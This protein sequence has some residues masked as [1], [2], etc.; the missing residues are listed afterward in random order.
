[1][2]LWVRRSAGTVRGWLSYSLGWVWST[3]EN[4][5]RPLQS[6]AGRHLISA[7]VEGPLPAGGIFDVRV[8]YGAGLP[9]T[10][11]PEPE[12]AAPVFTAS[13]RQLHNDDVPNSP[14]TPSDPGQ[15]YLRIDAELERTWSGRIGDFEFEVTPYVKVLNALNRRDA[16]FYHFDRDVG[17]AEPLAGLPLLP[18]VGLTW[19]F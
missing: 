10:A 14:G 4:R 12:V 15:P 19:T 11:I 3:P 5:P 16:L 17:A 13:F 1:M 6:F 9:Y 7:G 2:D 18:L 8:S